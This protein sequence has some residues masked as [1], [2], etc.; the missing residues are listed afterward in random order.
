MS[1][2]LRMLIVEDSEDDA[3]LLARALRRAGYDVSFERV[4]TAGTM[5]E[6]L[7]RQ[8]WNLIIADHSMPHFSGTEALE[9]LKKSGLDIPFIFVSGTI[10]EDTAVAAMKA[11]AQDYIMKGYLTRLIPA[12]ERE[13]REAEVRIQRRRAEQQ[14]QLHRRRQAVLYDINLAMTSTLDLKKVLDLLL[15]KNDLFLP[16]SATTVS[17]INKADGKLEPVAYHNV[18]EEK[19]KAQEL[20][21]GLTNVVFEIK[22]PLVV[23]NLQTHPGLQ[24]RDFYLDQ[25]FV[26]YLGVP[27]IIRGEVLGVLS[28]YT[29]GEHLFANEEVEFLSTLAGQ[30]AIAIHNSQLYEQTKQQALD[31]EKANKVKDEFLSVMS[32]EMRTP[33]T[34]VLGNARM[35]L[36]R[37]LGEIAAEH[38]EALGK[39]ISSSNNLLNMVNGILEATRI[40]AQTV[41][42]ES[43]LV[44]LSNFLDELRSDYNFPLDK[45]LTLTWDYPSEL[46]SMR[47]DK[48]KLKQILQNL[49]NNAIK[50]TE[51]GN[52]TI[53]ARH[54]PEVKTVEFKVADTGIGIPEESL[55]FIFEIFRQLDSSN[56]RSYGGVGLGLYIVKRYTDLLRGTVK[57]ESEPGKGLTFTVTIPSEK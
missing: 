37:V 19:W 4:E 24:D 48:D 13:L 42:L 22:S 50:F 54:S 28:F 31:L 23:G 33:L 51:R 3:L 53:S 9:L 39:I 6:A 30:A 36:D 55:P 29:K 57:V 46:P 7:A 49:I 11:G 10:G 20:E 32:H 5:T 40:E 25:G 21:H 38:E 27:L 15:E 45:E 26:S 47:T 8:T 17:L 14:V 35:I 56:K 41:K 43:H 44:R 34:V 1:K 18:D 12:I 52:V 2:A 16:Y